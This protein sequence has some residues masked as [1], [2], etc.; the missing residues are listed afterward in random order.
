MLSALAINVN[1]V[2]ETAAISANFLLNYS[3]G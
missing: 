1:M 2:S 3:M